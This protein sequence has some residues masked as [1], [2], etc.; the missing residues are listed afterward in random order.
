MMIIFWVL[1]GVGI[2]YVLKGNGKID[3]GKSGQS[4]AEAVLK[5]RYVNGEIDD[6][7][8]SQMLKTLRN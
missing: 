8:Y 1:L 6:E 2:Y 3:I 4:D 5:Q 7:T